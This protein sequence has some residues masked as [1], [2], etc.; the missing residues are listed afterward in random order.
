M[1]QWTKPLIQ[2]QRFI[3]I[4]KEKQEDRKDES[5]QKSKRRQ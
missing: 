2:R 5:L 1:C 3:K 4:K